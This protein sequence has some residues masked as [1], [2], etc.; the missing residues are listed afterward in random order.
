M[1]EAELVFLGCKLVRPVRILICASDLF[2]LAEC[3]RNFPGIKA[4]C[5]GPAA[6]PPI[7]LT[8]THPILAKTQ[9]GI[10]GRHHVLVL[11]HPRYRLGF[12]SV[13]NVTSPLRRGDH[14]FR[15]ESAFSL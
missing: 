13:E 11:H 15:D 5:V 3:S 1:R 7:W 12:V 4:S 10:F 8:M 9:S 2:R 14:Y 6:R